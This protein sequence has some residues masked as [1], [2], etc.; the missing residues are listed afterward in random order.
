MLLFSTPVSRTNT[1][2]AA[3]SHAL[4]AVESKE[5]HQLRALLRQRIARILFKNE[6]I[7]N[8]ALFI[9]LTTAIFDSRHFRTGTTKQWT[10]PGA[11]YFSTLVVTLIGRSARSSRY[12]STFAFCRLR[13]NNAENKYVP[14]PAEA[15]PLIVVS[16][17]W[18]AR[19]SAWCTRSPE[20]TFFGVLLIA[21]EPN[22]FPS[23]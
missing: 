15:T 19:S 8:E 2:S 5:E 1:L 14:C 22:A 23:D 13:A 12:S 16:F 18:A 11:F 20:C 3:C 6:T 9:S 7:P 4:L 10:F 21:F 17:Q